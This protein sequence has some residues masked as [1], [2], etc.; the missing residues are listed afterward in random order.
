[1]ANK[2]TVNLKEYDYFKSDLLTFKKEELD[3]IKGLKDKIQIFGEFVESNKWF[4]L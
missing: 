2:I 3:V 4:M 1:M